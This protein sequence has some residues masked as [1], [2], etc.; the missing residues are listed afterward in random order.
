[1]S[2]KVENRKQER[3]QSPPDPLSD[4]PDFAELQLTGALESETTHAY[5]V[6]DT[7]NCASVRTAS[8]APRT[9]RKGIKLGR[10]ARCV[11]AHAGPRLVVG[12]TIRHSARCA[13]ESKC[14]VS[15][16][17]DRKQFDVDLC[18]S[19]TDADGP[20]LGPMNLTAKAAAK[21]H[22]VGL[23]LSLE[24]RALGGYISGLGAL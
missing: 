12:V 7:R 22:E 1:M 13:G 18:D 8:R 2:R 9:V 16:S 17:R 23:V 10:F 4:P 3:L 15:Q 20:A 14:V 11:E 19:P 21:I 5:A 6:V 24:L